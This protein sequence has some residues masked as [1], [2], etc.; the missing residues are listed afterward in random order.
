MRS[1]IPSANLAPRLSRSRRS[2]PSMSR[3]GRSDSPGTSPK[4]ATESGS[5]PK[6]ADQ[7]S[8]GVF[9]SL[10]QELGARSKGRVNGPAKDTVA[11][12]LRGDDHH[13]SGGDRPEAVATL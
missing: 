1:R 12:D 11:V 5:R 4:V 13:D 2:R 10:H 3:P 6:S 9:D 8:H 7:R